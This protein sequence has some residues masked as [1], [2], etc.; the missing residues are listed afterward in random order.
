MVCQ[1]DPKAVL[2]R[3]LKGLIA[4]GKKTRSGLVLQSKFLFFI[5]ALH[6]YGT[7]AVGDHNFKRFKKVWPKDQKR[8][9]D[10]IQILVFY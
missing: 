2:S 9:E 5:D 6:P 7:K 1:K 8:S 4:F 10:A 3:N